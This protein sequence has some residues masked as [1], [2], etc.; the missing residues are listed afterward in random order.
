MEHQMKLAR[1]RGEDPD[2]GQWGLQQQQG[3]AGEDAA[4]RP[5]PVQK[6]KPHER[7][8]A[9]PQEAQE[10]VLPNDVTVRGLASLLGAA[11]PSFQK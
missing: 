2:A 3:G 9:Q 8:S 11:V 4:N 10:I 1:M 5:R 6:L 7:V